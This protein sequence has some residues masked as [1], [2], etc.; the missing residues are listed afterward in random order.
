MGITINRLSSSRLN[1]YNKGYYHVTKAILVDSSLFSS[2]PTRSKGSRRRI[3]L[4]KERIPTAAVIKC[5]SHRRLTDNIIKRTL[6]LTLLTTMSQARKAYNS[7]TKMIHLTW[8]AFESTT[9]RSTVASYSKSKQTSNNMMQVLAVAA[10]AISQSTPRTSPTL[11]R[12]NRHEDSDASWNESMEKISWI[13]LTFSRGKM[14]K[15]IEEIDEKEGFIWPFYQCKERTN[16]PLCRLGMNEVNWNK[17]QIFVA[18]RERTR[19]WKMK[20]LNGWWD[21]LPSLSCCS[22]GRRTLT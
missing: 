4:L 17:S 3:L 15:M 9:T 16:P 20:C 21:C 10:A 14:T 13:T 7:L 6:T 18:A 5:P 22:F 11:R 1:L 2:H 8:Q 12:R 19:R